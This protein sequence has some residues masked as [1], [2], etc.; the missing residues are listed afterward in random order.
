MIW[1][2]W[3]LALLLQRIS[4]AV[5]ETNGLDASTIT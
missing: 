3:W 4:A 2:L 5:N 1:N